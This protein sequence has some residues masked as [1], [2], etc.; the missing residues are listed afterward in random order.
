MKTRIQICTQNLNLSSLG[1]LKTIHKY[2]Q[3][4]KT[5]YKYFHIKD[6]QWCKELVLL[7]VSSEYEILWETY[8][9]EKIDTKHGLIGEEN[10]HHK[11]LSALKYVVFTGFINNTEISKQER[12][13]IT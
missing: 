5:I 4:L 3:Y 6:N 12:Q 2:F 9:S 1:Y 8:N 13:Y 10:K 11:K 7:Q